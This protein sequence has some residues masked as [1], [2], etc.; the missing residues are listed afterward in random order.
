MQFFHFSIEDDS[1]V[2]H[3]LITQNDVAKQQLLCLMR[4]DKRRSTGVYMVDQSELVGHFVMSYYE[5]VCIIVSCSIFWSAILREMHGE[6]PVATC[7]LYSSRYPVVLLLYLY[8]GP[9]VLSSLS[10]L[11]F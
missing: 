4:R 1:R 8:G 7:Y 11:I 2:S 5:A 6:W 9:Y 10:V 3:E